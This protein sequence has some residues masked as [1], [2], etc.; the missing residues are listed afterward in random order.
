MAYV[1]LMMFVPL[2]QIPTTCI[3]HLKSPNM[4]I[5]RD[6][7]R[8]A[9]HWTMIQIKDNLIKTAKAEWHTILPI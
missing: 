3:N 1:E 9:F 4:K 7:S 5:S 2:G 8:N 6:D